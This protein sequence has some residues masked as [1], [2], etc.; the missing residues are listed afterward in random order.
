MSWHYLQGQEAASWEGSSLDGAPDALLKLIP[1]PEKSCSQDKPTDASNRSRSGM[2]LEPLTDGLGLEA[3]MSCPVGSPA[4]TLPP[5]NEMPK[6]LKGNTLAF[7]ERWQE[8]SVKYD[9]DS[10]SWKT[11]RCLWEEVLPWSSVTLPKWGMAAGG[12]VWEGT[13]PDFPITV[14]A[15]GWLP[16]PTTS[17][18]ASH[19]NDA[20]RFDCLSAWCRA[21]FGAGY[22]NPRFWETIMGWPTSWTDAEQS[23]TAKFRQWLDSHGK[24]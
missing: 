11:H 14:P 13:S 17:S 3:L 24:R 1:T 12:V 7:G 19:K 21:R 10:H 15:C 22:P 16:T 4:P 5:A 20:V 9:R 8:L 18:A 6:A 23:A 2:T